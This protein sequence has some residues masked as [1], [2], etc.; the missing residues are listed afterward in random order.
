MRKNNHRN[1]ATATRLSCRFIFAVA[2]VVIGQLAT[3]RGASANEFTTQ[4]DLMIEA[5][6]PTIEPPDAATSSAPRKASSA[7]HRRYKKRSSA[8]K[9]SK[10]KIG[11]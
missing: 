7:K 3:S 10:E 8:E 5:P 6:A 4:Y 2:V 11:Q 1:F 9:P